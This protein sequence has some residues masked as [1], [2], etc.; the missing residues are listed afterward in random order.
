MKKVFLFAVLAIICFFISMASI[1]R[2][3]PVFL[4][5]LIAS[6]VFIILAGVS[7]VKNKLINSATDEKIEEQRKIFE[8]YLSI[9]DNKRPIVTLSVTRTKKHD[10][11][12]RMTVGLDV[13]I[14]EDYD[15]EA[16]KYIVSNGP[17]EIGELSQASVDKLEDNGIDSFDDALFLISAIDE[18]K[19]TCKISVYLPNSN[20]NE[21]GCR[22]LVTPIMGTKYHNDDGSSRTDILSQMNEGDELQLEVTEYDGKPAVAVTNLSGQRLGFI[23][24]EF[25]VEFSNKI[26]RN[27][28]GKVYLTNIHVTNERVIYADTAINIIDGN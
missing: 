3:I 1:E 5:L 4:F 20:Y 10:N 19:G 21:D 17:Y 8:K 16:P 18:E 22:L 12:Y 13:V 25:S 28:I 24:K 14:E 15:A 11:L 26:K 2:S 6:I 23:K 7:H 27:I 9:L